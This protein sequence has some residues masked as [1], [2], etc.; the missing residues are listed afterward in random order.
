MIGRRTTSILA[1]GGLAV[2]LMAVPATSQAATSG[3]T[4]MRLSMAVT[5]ELQVKGIALFG[6]EPAGGTMI[7]PGKYAYE[8][9]IIKVQQA[10][11]GKLMHDGA[12]IFTTGDGYSL[13]TVVLND[14][15]LSLG[16]E[17]M[18]ANV[19]LG[20]ATGKHSGTGT[21]YKTMK[22]FTVKPTSSSGP[23]DFSYTL[24]IAKNFAAVAGD[25]LGS[26]LAA[27]TRLGSAYSECAP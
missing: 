20:E 7:E 19:F 8:L 23:C 11:G 1:S 24:K 9:P 14:I 21:F 5:Q 13:R 3:T 17:A 2:A 4:A 16:K 18:I 10:S 12:L 6:R 15:R 22:V 25:Q 27:G 26:F